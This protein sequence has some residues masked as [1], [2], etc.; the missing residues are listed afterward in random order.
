MELDRTFLLNPYPWLARMRAEDPVHFDGEAWNVFLYEDVRNVL[1]N[2]QLFSSGFSGYDS[3]RAEE[4][5]REKPNQIF[6]VPT[7]YT[8]LTADPPL[9]DELRGITSSFFSPSHL[10]KMEDYIRSVARSLLQSKERLDLISDF[11]SPLPIEVIVRMLGLSKHDVSKVKK[12]SDAVALNLG[13]DSGMPTDWSAMVEMLQ[14]V[15]DALDSHQS[16]ED[17]ITK[18]R[19]ATFRGMKLSRIEQVAYTVLLLIAGNETTTNL[20]GNAAVLLT[21]YNKWESVSTDPTWTVEE[22]L[23]FSP[24]VRRTYRV[25]RR[26][27]EIRGRKIKE[28]DGIRVWIASANRDQSVFRD[29]DLFDPARKPN[30]HLSFGS[31]IH[32]CLGAPL[33]R[34]EAR[35][36]LEELR[37]FK[38]KVETENLE[39]VPNI[40]LNGFRSVPAVVG[41]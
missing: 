2:Y 12:W 36:A 20:I 18:I 4:I 40:I 33:A 7:R 10:S 24:P 35:V 39:P 28:G 38:V 26:D 30:P 1:N 11:A 29:P 41:S 15:N 3:E 22:V 25:A 17:L 14:F 8:M 21:K 9:H 31:G 13:K 5:R 16:G 19:Q 34:L 37:N 6:A 32:L 27:V 23:R